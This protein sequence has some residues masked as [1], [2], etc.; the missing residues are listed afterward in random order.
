MKTTISK[1]GNS[2]AIRIP[3][4]ILERLNLPIG[5]DF[6]VDIENG[7]IILSPALHIFKIIPMKTLLKGVKK[8]KEYWSVSPMGKEI[9]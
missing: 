8:Q 9:W 3:A 7:R 5:T 6:I 4:K 1:W 2:A